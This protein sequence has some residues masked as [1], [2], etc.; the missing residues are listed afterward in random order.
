VRRTERRFG[1]LMWSGLGK[2]R[3]VSFTHWNV[4][5]ATAGPAFV[6]PRSGQVRTLVGV[7]IRDMASRIGRRHV[8]LPWYNLGAKGFRAAAR[9]RDSRGW[10]NR[11]LPAQVRAT[12][13][14]FRSGARYVSRCPARPSG[15]PS[16]VWYSLMPTVS[17]ASRASF[18]TGSYPKT[19][20]SS[21]PPPR[22][23]LWTG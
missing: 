15:A 9:R 17:T 1:V 23:S 12:L 11:F 7:W 4:A 16:G 5:C 10:R 20:L 3:S 13:R 2:P 22:V 19:I 14:P 18:A 21:P 6:I 8:R